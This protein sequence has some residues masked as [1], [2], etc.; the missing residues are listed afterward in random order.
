[1]A[2]DKASDLFFAVD[3]TVLPSEKLSEDEADNVS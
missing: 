3:F 1:M 2:E